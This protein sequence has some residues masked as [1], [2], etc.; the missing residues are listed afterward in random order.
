MTLMVTV[1]EN[2]KTQ[3]IVP[4]VL[5]LITA[6]MHLVQEF[7]KNVQPTVQVVHLIQHVLSVITGGTLT[8]TQTMTYVKM[9]VMMHA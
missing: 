2:A 8:L 3:E 5:L 1:S 9:S 4:F 7:V 6:Q